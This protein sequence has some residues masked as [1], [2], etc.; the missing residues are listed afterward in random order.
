MTQSIKTFV[1]QLQRRETKQNF[2]I[3]AQLHKFGVVLVSW[4][5]KMK[6]FVSGFPLHVDR[7][8]IKSKGIAICSLW[9]RFSFGFT[10]DDEWLLSV[11]KWCDLEQ[12][13]F[14]DRL[15]YDSRRRMDWNKINYWSFGKAG[16][17]LN[18]AKIKRSSVFELLTFLLFWNLPSASEAK[19]NAT[20]STKLSRHILLKFTILS[21]VKNQLLSQYE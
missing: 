16:L 12:H 13:L 9:C 2:M 10:F 4:D 6:T 15:F 14:S 3:Y 11:T 21:K 7:I 20:T 18:Q 1:F 19:A 17:F 5:F 8:L